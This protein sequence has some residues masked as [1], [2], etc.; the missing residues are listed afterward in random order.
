M[1]AIPSPNLALKLASNDNYFTE[2]LVGILWTEFKLFISNWNRF[3]LYFPFLKPKKRALF[4]WMKSNLS[5][6]LALKLASNEN[7]FTKELVGILWTEFKLF[8]SNWNRFDLY[9]PF[10]KPKKWACLFWMKSNLS[11]N[12]VL[13]L[14]SNDNYF[15]EELVGILWTEFKLFISN[16]NR[17]GIYFPFLKPKKWAL[18]FFF[19]FFEW[20]QFPVQIWPWI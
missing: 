17:F 19:F 5:Q 7:Y 16:W 13:K 14:A 4:F 10:L 20:K 3:D 9:L 15:T 8:I 12:L 1:K 18:F 11:P 2:E 6:N